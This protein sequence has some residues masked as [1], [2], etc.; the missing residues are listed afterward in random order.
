MSLKRLERR[1]RGSAA[2]ETI[3]LRREGKIA[4]LELDNPN[5]GFLTAHLQGELNRLTLALEADPEI[6][7]VILTGKAP[8]TFITHYSPFELT[9]I[10]GVVNGIKSDKALAKVRKQSTFMTRWV[11]RVSRWPKLFNWLN[12]RCANTDLSPLFLGARINMMQTRWQHSSKVFIAALNG[13]AMGGGCEM[14][15]ACDFR[16]M[17]R[18][19]GVIGLPESISGI[20]PGAGGTQR[21]SRLLGASKAI[22]LILTGTMLNADEA[23]KVGLVNRAVDADKLMDEAMTLAEQMAGQ[24]PLSIQGVKRSIHIGIQLPLDRG[25]AVEADNFMHSIISRDAAALGSRYLER[26]DAA[27][28]NDGGKMPV[29]VGN[30]AKETWVE[31]RN[32]KTVKTCG[33]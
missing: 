7:V 33:K 25:I 29:E 17:A 9:D 18:G 11:Y 5:G 22:E 31:F 32:G 21:M 12:K 27:L 16:L 13:Y 8:T 26:L 28:A 24:P 10:S 20:I 3:H 6:R 30:I 15:M 14:A 2:S 4:I 19:E 1:Q 23:E